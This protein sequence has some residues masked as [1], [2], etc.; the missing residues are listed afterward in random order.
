MKGLFPARSLPFPN[1]LDCHQFQD[2][3]NIGLVVGLCSL[4][5]SFPSVLV[6]G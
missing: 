5:W 1:S 6:D 3:E 4:G 2:W